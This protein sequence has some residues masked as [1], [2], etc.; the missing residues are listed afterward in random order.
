MT[1]LKFNSSL[2]ITV[3]EILRHWRSGFGSFELMRDWALVSY[4]STH[5]FDQGSRC[6][7]CVQLQVTIKSCLHLPHKKKEPLS[8][9]DTHKKQ[10][11]YLIHIIW[12]PVLGS[13]TYILNNAKYSY[14]W[15]LILNLMPLDLIDLIWIILV[16]SLTYIKRRRRTYGKLFMLH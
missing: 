13:S 12:N 5:C 8:S 4:F 2:T 7:N 10:L 3:S 9:P 14:A 16:S 6:K 1:A 15:L 11:S